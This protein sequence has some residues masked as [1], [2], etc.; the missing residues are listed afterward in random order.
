MINFFELCRQ[1]TG[2]L[3]IEENDPRT[4]EPNVYGFDL[5][6]GEYEITEE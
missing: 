6:E 1:G 3:W 5:G 4:D 2:K